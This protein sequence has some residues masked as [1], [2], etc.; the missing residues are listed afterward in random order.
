M[1]EI[2][3]YY[4]T[5]QR[6]IEQQPL[7]KSDLSQR[8]NNYTAESLFSQCFQLAAK[9]PRGLDLLLRDE[10]AYSVMFFRGCVNGNEMETVSLSRMKEKVHEFTWSLIEQ[11]E[12]KSC[13]P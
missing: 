2:N 1:H 13:L 10:W 9:T 3:M 11:G 4:P 5:L 12:D 6:R 7:I 8:R